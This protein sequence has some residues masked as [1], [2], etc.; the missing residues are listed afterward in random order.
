MAPRAK[1][2]AAFGTVI[3]EPRPSMDG[4]AKKDGVT[5]PVSE[6][7]LARVN[8]AVRY[9]L[10]GKPP[11]SWF[12]PSQPLAPQAQVLADNRQLDYPV[13]VN[14]VWTPR[15]EG[16]ETGISF[17][18]L[19]NLAD[20]SDL[21][22][23]AIETRKDQLCH[24]EW[25][26]KPKD[27]DKAA[28]A[29]CQQLTDFL[30]MPN[31]EH[32]WATW[33]RMLLEDLLVID[34]PAVYPRL[35]RGGDVYSLDLMDG[36]MFKRIIGLDGRTPMPPDV[37]YQQVV[38]GMPATDY[39][40]DE[41]LYMPRNPRTNRLYGY[42]PVEQIIVTINI[43]LR[44]QLHKL[45]YYT[46]GSAPDLMIACPVD[47]QPEQIKA[48]QDTF[49]ALLAGNTGERRR[50]RFIP[51]GEKPYDVKEQA[52]KDDF[53]EWLARIVCFCF[54]LPPTAFVK[55]MN[56]ATADTAQD[57]ALEEGL[58]PLMQW[59]TSMM[60]QLIWRWWKMPDLQFA[61]QTDT[62]VDHF[63]QAQIDQIYLQNNVVTPDEV[64]E[65]MG[66]EPLTDEQREE[67][68]P[69]PPAMGADEDGNPIPADHPKNVM[70]KPAGAPKPTGKVESIGARLKKKRRSAASTATAQASLS[71]EPRSNV[72]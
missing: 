13:A 30:A 14:T 44:R 4:A 50:T 15:G 24:L 19:R 40:R 58:A 27:P 48:M 70:P 8:Q 22:R 21:V 52:L 11:D 17:P 72:Y 39:H 71:R 46:D 38:K 16:T 61:W 3:E 20:S 66:M 2:P 29:R 6:G 1:M 9:L 67:L 57:V 51:G 32:E 54:S 47:W 36:A 68:N 37:A 26:I 33:L 5:K 45:Q 23:L 63:T 64:R 18:Q 43:A 35:T 56:R 7:I 49:D 28:D 59:V 42:S 65:T 55:Q 41:L 12:G 31:R 53:D 60:N 25:T 10:S 62:E 69:T 34:A